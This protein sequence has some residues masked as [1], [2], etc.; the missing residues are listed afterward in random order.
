MMDTRRA[1]DQP[2]MGFAGLASLVSTVPAWTP[3]AP[4]RA[5]SR[6]RGAW[7]LIGLLVAAVVGFLQHLPGHVSPTVPTPTPN[8]LYYPAQT[9]TPHTAATQPYT[10]PLATAP[11][12]PQPSISEV[13]PPP[14]T[15]LT[16]SA[17][18]I[19]YCLAQKVRLD[20]M[21]RIVDLR[22]GT[23]VRA[24]NG[25]V[26][27]YNLRCVSYHYRRADM[28]EARKRVEALRPTL[29][30]EAATQVATWR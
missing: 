24:F 15:D 26:D 30:A 13:K 3:P 18:Q 25:L 19:L 9:L 23:Q 7:G 5:S 1:A 29:G 4:R 16:L 2:A 11:P 8:S 22:V 14:G 27:D 20:A 28:E 17:S 10:P 12:W 6:P 21:E